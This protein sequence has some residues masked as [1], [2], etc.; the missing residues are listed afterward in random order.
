MDARPATE[1]PLG[2][3]LDFLYGRGFLWAEHEA[4]SGCVTVDR[5]RMEIPDLTFPFDVRGGLRRFRDTRCLLRELDVRLSEAGFVELLHGVLADL[6]GVSELDV[7]FADGVVLV[8]VRAREGTHVTFRLGAMPSE[9]GSSVLRLLAHDLRAYGRLPCS[10]RQFVHTLLKQAVGSAALS[11]VSH[12]P[13]FGIELVGDSVEF[14]PLKLLLLRVFAQHGWKMP[15]LSDVVMGDLSFGDGRAILRARADDEDWTPRD[16]TRVAAAEVDAGFETGD[17]AMHDGRHDDALLSYRSLE[18]RL[19]CSPELVARL[20]DVLLADPTD[21][22]LGEAQSLCHDLEVRD[23]NSL[24]AAMGRARL[25]DVMSDAQQSVR[26]WKVV[27]K[28]LAQRGETLDRALCDVAIARRLAPFDVGAALTRLNSALRDEPRNRA[29]LQELRAAYERTGQQDELEDVLKRLTAVAQDAASL[30]DSYVDLARHLMERGQIGEARAFLE[31]ALLVTPHRFEILDALGETWVLSG[32]PARAVTTL[33]SAATAARHRG[34]FRTASRLL[35]RIGQLWETSLQNREQALAQ[36]RRALDFWEESPVDDPLGRA[37]QLR[38]AAHLCEEDRLPT[39]AVAYWMAALAALQLAE[40]RVEATSV[41]AVRVALA[42]THREIAAAYRRRGR[43]DMATEH[44]LRV[45]ELERRAIEPAAIQ[46]PAPLAESEEVVEFRDRYE[47]ST[48]RPPPLPDLS[49]LT[50]QSPLGRILHRAGKRLAAPEV[51]VA[52]VDELP[53]APTSTPD[54]ERRLSDARQAGD[55]GAVAAG[56]EAL[57]T[58]GEIGDARRLDLTFELAELL[59][60]ELEES[61][62]ALDWL[63]QVRRLDPLGYGARP[64]VLN[65]I[66]AIY[67]ERGSVDGQLEILTAK[68]QQAQSDD[69]RDTYRLLLAQLEWESRADP[70]AAASYLAVVLE[71][72]DRHEGARRLLAEIA[73]E[74]NEWAVAAEHLKI[75]L[76]VAGEGLDSVELEKRLAAI[77]LDRLARPDEALRH[78]QNVH[79]DAPQDAGAMDA[80]RRCHVALGDWNAYVD[81]LHEELRLML[82]LSATDGDD[83]IAAIDAT[84]IAEPLRIPVSHVL[85]DIARVTQDELNRPVQALELW[86][87]V[88][89]IWP[90]HLEA[91]ERRIDLDRKLEHDSD[92]P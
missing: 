82:G 84:S 15:D 52:E 58:D 27:S 35:L 6:Q 42:E 5:L 47:E 36:V 63:L 30:A 40:A 87:M 56:L 65:A 79:A 70:G 80:I 22:H 14:R 10:T 85:A 37:A 74:A 49:D 88:A 57:L 29:V 75:A 50:P 62:R 7:R 48:R 67:E 46:N 76:S 60:Y 34:E 53:E 86:I 20:L 72:D 68:L 32:D 16:E 24:L 18:G 43:D 73:E 11:A 1:N 90:E 45:H 61:D 31:R 78:Y 28:L 91:V 59:Y 19:G 12:K 3:N 69:L 41:A 54:L 39:E 44:E 55:D 26:Q 4:I 9:R 23:P 92:E 38:Y 17:G 83:W 81:S 25:A 64:G 71:R 8:A 51:D 66:E 89:E 77:Y 21:E 33:G 13:A 2:L